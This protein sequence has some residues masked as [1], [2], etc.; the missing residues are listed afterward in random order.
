MKLPKIQ[1]SQ[2]PTYVK[3]AQDI[4]LYVLFEHIE[5]EFD[6]CFLFE[7]LGEESRQSRFSVVGFDPA[8]IIRGKGNTLVFD[9]TSY[10][11]ANP[12]LALARIVPTDAITRNYAGGLIGYLGYDCV[13]YFEP[14][15]TV[16]THPLFDQF[17]FGVY[18][19]GLVFDK[20]T[21]ELFYFFYEN[22]RMKLIEKLMRKNQRKSNVQTK[23][24]RDTVT[25]EAYTRRFHEVKEEILA[26]NTFQT[27]LSYKSEYTITGDALSIYTKLRKIN[28]SPY[29]YYVKFGKQKIIGA[30]P[31]LLFRI[32]NGEM[33]TFPLAGTIQRGKTEKEDKQF[34]RKLLQDPKEIAEH[35]MLVDLHRNDLGRVA[36][37]GTVKVRSFMD[38]KRFQ[39]VQHIGSE[40][41]GI[42]KQGEDMFSALSHNF[43]AG[44]LSGAPKIESMK[45]IDRLEP[46]ARGP[47]GGGLGHFGFNGDCTFA[48]P[49][50]TLFISDTYAYT[51]A[52]SGIVYDSEMEKEFTEIQRKLQ[53]IQEAIIL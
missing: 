21:S 8:H 11:V 36:E 49:I 5:K 46:D 41:A 18:T 17:Q 7:S 3:L 13:N 19:D 43:P 39:H 22:S 12:Y 26:G 33:E 47:Y 53:S 30:S 34:A 9:D 1:L 15:I 14:S 32:R 40:I 6:S 51:Q 50:R 28:P 10:S 35:N 23:F 29:M 16:A 2:K 24:V 37:F 42:I 38:I 31:E 52:G 48:I 4:D 44:T 27:V 45:I 25:Y 20:V